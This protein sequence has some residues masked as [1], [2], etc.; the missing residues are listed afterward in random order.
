VL[1]VAPPDPP[2]DADE[3]DEEPAAPPRPPP[4]LPDFPPVA[5]DSSVHAWA[6]AKLVPIA[7]S[8]ARL[9]D[10]RMDMSRS[11]WTLP[12]QQ[13]RAK[14]TIAVVIARAMQ[15]SALHPLIS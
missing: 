7:K 4:P 5:G 9:F 8:Q 13:A 14:P 6:S 12:A 10:L 11:P 1:E 15:T 2:V 3:E